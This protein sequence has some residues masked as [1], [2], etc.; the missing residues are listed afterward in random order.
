MGIISWLIVGAIAGWLASI[1]MGKN[2]S[3]GLGANILV[4][5]VGGLL[6]GF[7]LGLL[8]LGGAPT[9]INIGSIITAVF[10]AVVLLFI[11]NAFSSRK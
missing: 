4:G 3:M 11:V 7:I 8:G 1:I 5:I 10:G 2:Q 9:G 6:G